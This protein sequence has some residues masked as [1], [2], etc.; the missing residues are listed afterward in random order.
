MS[1]YKKQVIFGVLIAVVIV[2]GLL[3]ISSYGYAKVISL[4]WGIKLPGD[5]AEIYEKDTGSSPHG[6]GIRYHIFEYNNTDKIEDSVSWKEIT[7]YVATATEFLNELSVPESQYTDFKHCLCY[8][9][10]QADN[11]ELIMFY[12]QDTGKVYIIEFFI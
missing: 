3:R 7:A 10:K 6:D 12:E 5:Y 11:S 4:N 1:K 9:S 2:A 8:Y